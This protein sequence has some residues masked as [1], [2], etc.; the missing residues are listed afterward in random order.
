MND[1]SQ[2]EFEAWV[3]ASHFY[4]PNDLPY[5][6][7]QASRKSAL[8]EAAQEFDSRVVDAGIWVLRNCRTSKKLS[9]V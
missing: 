8:E 3:L 5:L 6:A 4:I 7:W 9:G 1:K 2:K